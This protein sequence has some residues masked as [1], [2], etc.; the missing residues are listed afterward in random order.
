MTYYNVKYLGF[1]SNACGC[2]YFYGTCCLIK[3]V[4]TILH[5]AV[6]MLIVHYSEIYFWSV[7]STHSIPWCARCLSILELFEN[8]FLNRNLATDYLKNL[9]IEPCMR[10]GKVKDWTHGC[11]L[12]SFNFLLA[13]P[14]FLAASDIIFFSAIGNSLSY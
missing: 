1:L 7:V 5:L 4:M 14:H 3:M 6:Y 11:G 13:I 12:N 10:W 2:H 8:W 9:V